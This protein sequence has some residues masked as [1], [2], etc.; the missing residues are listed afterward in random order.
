MATAVGA[1]L[2][3]KE[4]AYTSVQTYYKATLASLSKSGTTLNFGVKLEIHLGSSTEIGTGSNRTRTAYVYDSSGKLLGSKLIK[5]S[6]T[7]WYADST[8]TETVSCT[9]T[10]GE[11]TG[12]LT[13]CYIRILYSTT[14]AYGGTNSCYWNGNVGNK[15]SISHDANT[16]TVD[17]N[18][19]VD[20]ELK[21][22]GDGSVALFDLYVNGKLYKQGIQDANPTLSYGDTYEYKIAWQNDGYEC[23]GSTNANGTIKGN[24]STV[25]SFEELGLCK[26]SDGTSYAD[27][28]LYLHD[29]DGYSPYIPYVHDGTGWK[30]TH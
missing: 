9:A 21:Y 17:L 2:I 16:Y 24:T 25:F 29:A 19:Q 5:D 23:T 20:G 13:G 15:F 11:G 30:R 14:D 18:I 1:T 3:A 26:I 8:Y 10:V 6:S 12:T 28:K 27:H 7:W 22:N 4:N